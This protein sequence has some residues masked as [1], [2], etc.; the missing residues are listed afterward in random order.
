MSG[1]LCVVFSDFTPYNAI[2]PTQNLGATNPVTASFPNNLFGDSPAQEL[3]ARLPFDHVDLVPQE[4]SDAVLWHSVYGW[5]AAPPS[6][7]PGA[8]STEQERASVALTAFA[9]GRDITD[10]LQALSPPDNNSS[11]DP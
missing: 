8:S 1:A 9:Q 3:A 7:G 11:V 6:P 4:L 10:A 2:R 5:T